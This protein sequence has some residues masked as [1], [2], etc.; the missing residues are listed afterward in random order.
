MVYCIETGLI[1]S[2]TSSRPREVTIR[3]HKEL[4]DSPSFGHLGVKSTIAHLRSRFYWVGYKRDIDLKCAE[5]QECQARKMPQ[6]VAKADLK[7]YHTGVPLE[8]VAIDLLGPLPETKSG[9]KYIVVIIDYF[10]KW[11]EAIPSSNIKAETVANALIKDFICRFGVPKEIHTDQG[12]QFESD[13]FRCLCLYL[14]IDKTRTSPFHPQ[15]DGMVER[16]NRTLEDMPS[17]FIS[18]TQNDW[19]EHLLVMLMAYRSY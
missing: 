6:N 8:R 16:F 3:D 15:S 7:Q 17:K 1:P 4:H 19:D 12:P 10:T 13:L 18:P 2:Q 9:S 14:Q 5:C 11:V